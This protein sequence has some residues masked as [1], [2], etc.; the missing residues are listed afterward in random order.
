MTH[1][2]TVG[3]VRGAA[4]VAAYAQVREMLVANFPDD[5]LSDLL[6]TLDGETELPDV[7]ARMIRDAREAGEF[8]EAIGRIAKELGERKARF[9]R[10]KEKMREGALALMTAADMPKLERPDFTAS[11]GKSRP[12][13]VIDDEEALPD[14]Y[15][16][17]K[18]T[19]DRTRIAEQLKAG[20]DVPGARMSEPMPSLT[21]RV[22]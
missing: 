15:F 11:L 10:R 1:A 3:N 19:P 13:V 16:V 8:E 18:A 9:G 6:D 7:I 21:V 2:N 12:A 20:V 22:R 5:D 17:V 14:D 4:L